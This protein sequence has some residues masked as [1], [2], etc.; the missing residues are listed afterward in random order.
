LRAR[1][2]LD[3]ENVVARMR[4]AGER[5]IRSDG[6]IV[7]AVVDGADDGVAV[8][9]TS[10]ARQMLGDLNAGH[11]RRSGAKLAANLGRRIG[12]QIPDI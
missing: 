8:G 3:A 7:V 9:E 12:L 5:E 11:T 1:G 10:E 6:V 2:R 4:I